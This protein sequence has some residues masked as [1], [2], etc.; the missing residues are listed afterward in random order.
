MRPITDALELLTAQ[1]EEIDG[2]LAQARRT[3]DGTGIAPLVARLV[4]HLA[5][6]QEL[7]YPVVAPVMS[8]DVLD[9]VLREHL[10][11]KLVLAELVWR[12]DDPPDVA[13]N[14]TYLAA[15][16]AGHA[17]WQE[18]R[19]FVAAAEALSPETLAEL[20]GRLHTYVTTFPI[21]A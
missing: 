1:H 19:L 13:A 9:E 15:L 12:G 11:I 14:L 18:Q 16:L 21:A 20:G 6:E 3:G 2:L 8:R 5:L 10:A 7:L 4:A 17:G